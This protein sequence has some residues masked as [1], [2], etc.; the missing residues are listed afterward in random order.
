MLPNLP[1]LPDPLYAL[2][3]V[4]HWIQE[5]LISPLDIILFSCFP[6]TSFVLITS[7]HIF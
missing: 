3:V 5:L 1:S 6:Q 2:G 7:W 4:A